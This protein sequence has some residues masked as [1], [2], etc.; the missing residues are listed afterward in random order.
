MSIEDRMATMLLEMR[1]DIKVIK[2]QTADMREASKDH[3]AR[4][5]KLERFKYAI[6]GSAAIAAGAAVALAFH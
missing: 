6:P 5:R 1:G 3:E 2:S 4:L